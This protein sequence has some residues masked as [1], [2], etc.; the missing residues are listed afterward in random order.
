MPTKK[1]DK[2]DIFPKG[3]GKTYGLLELVDGKSHIASKEPEDTVFT[4]PHLLTPIMIC[5]IV[6]TIFLTIVSILFDAPLEEIANPIKPPN[7]AKA[8]WYFLGL[9]EMVAYNAFWGGVAIPALFVVGLMAIPYIDRNPL[10]VGVWF[11]KTRSIAIN[12][13]TIFVIANLI[14]IIIGTFLRGPNWAF[15]WPW[16]DWGSPH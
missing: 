15:F 4:F 12:F 5:T 13:F 3:S 9:Q 10:G 6:V 16:E 1:I 2:Q 7:P 11:S 8:P 14:L